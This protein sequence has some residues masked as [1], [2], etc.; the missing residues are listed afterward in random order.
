MLVLA[1]AD[2]ERAAEGA[3]RAV[4]SNTG[5]LCVS[6]ERMY[7][8]DAIYDRFVERFVA[9]TE[10]MTLGATLDW[11]NDM[12][13]LISQDQLDTAVAHVE[14]AVAKGAKV[15][16]GGKARPDLGPYFF[17]PT[18]LESVSPQ[19]TC[20]GTETFGPV[21]SLYRV[22]SEAEAIERA[23]DGEYGLNAAVYSRDTARARQVAAR[24]KAG[25]VNINEAFAASFASLDAPMGGVRQSGMGRRQGAEG[26]L[27]YT[28][29]Q[30]VAT[31]R[32][33]RF[34][35]MFGMSD[36]GYAKTMTLALRAL[37]A[38]GRA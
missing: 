4:F 27:R 9:R 18:I 38:A 26:I 36:K 25:T 13:S 35:P 34:S 12:G 14:D 8:A 28:E 24:I 16:T 3:T 29:T 5:Q 21:V 31:Q 7:V 37:K 32:L 11:D 15:L 2:I 1:D 19:M 33:M 23:N 17:E 30:S 6:I 20:F 10:A 22:T